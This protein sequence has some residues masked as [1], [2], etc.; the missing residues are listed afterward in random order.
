MSSAFGPRAFQQSVAPTTQLGVALTEK[1]PNEALKRLRERR[2]RDVAFVLIE[3]A[4]REQAR[5]GNEH[6]V[7]ARG[8]RMIFRSRSTP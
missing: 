2:V 6:L 8:P 5:C 1:I 4:G 3:L 7:A